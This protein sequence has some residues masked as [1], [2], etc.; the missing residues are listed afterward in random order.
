[1]RLTIETKDGDLTIKVANTE[2]D[3]YVD[4]E[5]GFATFTFNLAPEENIEGTLTQYL[6]NQIKALTTI[7]DLVTELYSL[8]PGTEIDVDTDFY[9]GEGDLNLRLEVPLHHKAFKDLNL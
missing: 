8:D 6:D 3:G 4:K 1:M 9:W 5:D 2:W 7:K